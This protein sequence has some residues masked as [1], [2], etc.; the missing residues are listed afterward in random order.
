MELVQTVVQGKQLNV[1]SL[2]RRN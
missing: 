2:K 1:S